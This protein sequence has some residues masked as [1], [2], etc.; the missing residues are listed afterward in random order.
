MQA[1]GCET[2][3]ARAGLFRDLL[4]LGEGLVF[5]HVGMAAFLAEIRREGVSRPDRPQTRVLLEP[6]LRDH[7]P[8]VGTRGCPGHRLTAAKAGPLLIDGP[9]VAVVLQ[10]EVLPPDR[11]VLDVVVQL[12]D[13]EER[14]PGLLLVFEDVDQQGDDA[15]CGQRGRDGGDD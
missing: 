7:G 4:P 12:D 13:A 3:H 6:G 10:R 8:R 2:V 14:V 11:R 1:T 15:E 9:P 5:E